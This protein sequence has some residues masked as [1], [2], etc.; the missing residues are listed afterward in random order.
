M[1]IRAAVLDHEQVSYLLSTNL[2]KRRLSVDL[3]KH[4][5]ILKP[6]SDRDLAKL[7]LSTE[8]AYP[9]SPPPLPSHEAGARLVGLPWDK[10]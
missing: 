2:A 7:T 3:G 10:P 8:P 1:A 4:A 6:E 5:R 9:E